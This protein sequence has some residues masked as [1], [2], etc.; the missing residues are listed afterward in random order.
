MARRLAVI[1]RLDESALERRMEAAR[2]ADEYAQWQV[3]LLA[4]RGHSARSISEVT[5]VSRSW[6]FE[7]V[8][9]Y[10]ADGQASMGDRRAN[11]IPEGIHPVFLQP[12]ERL[13]PLTREAVANRPFSTLDQLQEVLA[14][15]GCA[16]LASASRPARSRHVRTSPGGRRWMGVASRTTRSGWC[17]GS[18]RRA[19]PSRRDGEPARC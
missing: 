6:L 18:G 16:S 17:R 15:C 14:Q 8:R 7:I 11:R 12:A 4:T 10:N 9:R 1:G 13:W 2:K 19:G 5:G 3:I